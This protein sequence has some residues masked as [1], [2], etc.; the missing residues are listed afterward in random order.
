MTRKEALAKVAASTAALLQAGGIEDLF[1]INEW[2]GT[3]DE[4]RINWAMDEVIR[5]LY[6]MGGPRGG[7]R[8]NSHYLPAEESGL[9]RG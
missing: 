9:G 3:S 7:H 5:R 8:G 2:E 6:R 1:G 4:E